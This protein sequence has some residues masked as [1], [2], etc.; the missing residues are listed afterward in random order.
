[1]QIEL[2]NEFNL[3]SDY[4]ELTQTFKIAPGMARNS[5]KQHQPVSTGAAPVHPR[6]APFSDEPP[7]PPRWEIRTPESK[8][9]LQQQQQYPVVQNMLACHPSLWRY[10]A[11]TRHWC[12]TTKTVT[13]MCGHHRRRI[14][15]GEVVELETHH[16]RS[17]PR[18]RGRQTTTTATATTST[19]I[20]HSNYLHLSHFYHTLTFVSIL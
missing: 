8:R 13:R 15:S 11:D 20:F 17:E 3:I 12:R 6:S 10:M 5:S 9:Q 16:Q 14:N 7:N 2:E 18:R 1:M 19:T 4:A